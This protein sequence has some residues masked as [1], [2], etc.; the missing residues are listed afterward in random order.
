MRVKFEMTKRK[1]EETMTNAKA[2]NPNE[3]RK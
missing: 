2:E 1:Y 3:E